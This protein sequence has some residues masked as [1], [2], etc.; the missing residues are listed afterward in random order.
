M[1]TRGIL[2]LAPFLQGGAGRAIAD[3]A[4]AQHDLGHQVTVVASASGEAGYGNYPEYLNQLR[5]AGVTL[6]LCDSLFKRELAL[7]LQVLELLRHRVDADAV[8]VVH[9]HAAVPAL[10]GRLFA[11]HSRRRIPVVQTQHGWGTS[12][13]PAQAAGDLAVLRDVDRVVVT[14]PATRDL[15]IDYGVPPWTLTVIPCGV[16]AHAPGPPPVEALRVLRPLRERGARVI[17][18]IGSVTA[19]KNQQLVVEALRALGD[20]DVVAVF[21]GEGGEALM[22]QAAMLGISRQVIACGYQPHAARWLP[23]LDLLVLPSKS[24]GQGLAVLEAFRAGVPVVASNIPPLAQ[25]V[26]HQHSGFLFQPDDAGALATVVRAA[27]AL[28]GHERDAITSAA[29]A[30][31]A[32]SFTSDRMVARH[33]ALYAQVASSTAVA[34]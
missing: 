2:H 24:E 14:S 11:G 29:R 34:A 21:I 3:L 31:F 30:R 4:C 10:V 8:D 6:H 23:L 28:P 17:G 19:N 16:S 22:M 25:T 33:E 7:N 1:N 9:A 15:L 26:Q 20:L 27:L 32:E 5:E 18:C 12:K 13:T